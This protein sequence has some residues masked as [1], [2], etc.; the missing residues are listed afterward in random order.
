MTCAVLR[1]ALRQADQGFGE[2]AVTVT[3]GTSAPPKA[4]PPEAGAKPVFTSGVFPLQLSSGAAHEGQVLE[5]LG[6]AA[7]RLCALIVPA[8]LFVLT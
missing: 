1:R 7:T 8:L 5:A 4:S 3:E 6:C 2:C